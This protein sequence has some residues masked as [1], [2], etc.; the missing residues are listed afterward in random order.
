MR[1]VYT[2]LSKTP[3]P[4]LPWLPRKTRLSEVSEKAEW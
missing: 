3:E 1:E 2:Y 4:L